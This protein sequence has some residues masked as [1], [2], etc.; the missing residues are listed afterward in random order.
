MISNPRPA[1][2]LPHHHGKPN[3]N[4]NKNI[5][6]DCEDDEDSRTKRVALTIMNDDESV[7]SIED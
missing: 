7:T 5:E 6:A 2:D 4:Q 3:V 1:P